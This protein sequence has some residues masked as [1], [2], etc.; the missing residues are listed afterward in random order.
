MILLYVREDIHLK[1]LKGI[2][3][4]GGFRSNV[5]WN[6]LKKKEMIAKLLHLRAVRKNLDT[7][8]SKCENFIMLED[9]NIQPKS[10]SFQTFQ[11]IETSISDFYKMVLTVFKVY[12]KKK[13]LPITIINISL[14]P[15]LEMVYLMNW[16][17]LKLQPYK[18]S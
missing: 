8:S 1:L 4:K 7:Y 3:F 12:F 16:P 5:C 2:D 13:G 15:Y 14:T 9:F 6:K 18:S 11:I 10:K 17:D